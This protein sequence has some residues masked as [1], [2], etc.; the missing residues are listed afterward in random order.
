MTITLTPT[1]KIVKI[2]GVPCRIWEGY[3]SGG[4]KMHAFITRVAVNKDDDTEE[5]QQELQEC[6]PPSEDIK[7]YPMHLII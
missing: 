3:T 1:T 6:E 5:F 2:N 4:I 7:G